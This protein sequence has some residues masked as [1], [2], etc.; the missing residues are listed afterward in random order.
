MNENSPTWK[1]AGFMEARICGTVHENFVMKV[2]ILYIVRSPTAM[3]SEA[4]EMLKP[5]CLVFPFSAV[6]CPTVMALRNLSLISTTRFHVI[7]D[8]ST[9]NLTNLRESNLVVSVDL[10]SCPFTCTNSSKC[11]EVNCNKNNRGRDH[12]DA[13]APLAIIR[14]HLSAAAKYG[15]QIVVRLCLYHIT[16]SDT[17]YPWHNDI[18]HNGL[19]GHLAAKVSRLG[20]SGIDK[21]C[22]NLDFA[23]NLCCSVG[24]IYTAKCWMVVTEVVAR[25]FLCKTECN[26]IWK[27]TRELYRWYQQ[28]RLDLLHGKSTVY[29]MSK[30]VFIVKHQRVWHMSLFDVHCSLRNFFFCKLAWISFVDAQLLQTS[31]HDWGKLSGSILS[32]WTESPEKSFVFLCRLMEHASIQGSC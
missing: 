7:V 18:T 15:C 2:H 29:R 32:R 3:I 14:Q 21:Q 6:P 28:V 24:K 11:A 17:K 8:S 9:S 27:K 19:S 30:S 20:E 1:A 23:L 31:E 13:C 10:V 4:T 25:L 12:V 26:W 5:V 16:R 22:S